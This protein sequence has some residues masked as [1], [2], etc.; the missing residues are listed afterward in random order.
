[1]TAFLA[2]GSKAAGFA[3][4]LRFFYLGDAAQASFDTI[5][6]RE[7]GGALAVATM[8]LGNF[9]ALSQTNMT[10]LLAYS[11][12]A[13][14]G[15]ALLGF[16]VLADA[17]L[18]AVLFYLAVYYVMNL[19]A[20]WVLMLVANATGREDVDAFRGL[21]RRG[22]AVAAVA[23][24]VFLFSLA[25]I[26]P[27]AGFFGKYFVFKAALERGMVALVVIGALN[28]VV[29][30]YYYARV[31]KAMFLDEARDGDPAIRI[32]PGELGV[33]VVLSV[34]TVALVLNFN[35]LL[36]LVYTSR[37]ILPGS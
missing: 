34:A 29:S 8:T 9:A 13:H 36:D 4:L 1:V 10:R 27:L 24:A 31:V 33:V 30:L 22:G 3:M 12:I 14:A 11:S 35:W 16:V 20:F 15:Y 19:G 7:L 32:R 17:G 5:P 37:P 26:P 28:S 18:E 23:M 21:A 2:V 6:L 25:G